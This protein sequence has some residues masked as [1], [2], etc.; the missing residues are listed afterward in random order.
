MLQ[1]LER[2]FAEGE[3][4]PKLTAKVDTVA[5]MVNGL[6]VDAK[7]AVVEFWKARGYDPK[8]PEI[9]REKLGYALDQE[10]ALGGV[11]V[12][13]MG[14]KPLFTGYQGVVGKRVNNMLT[15][16]NT[17]LKTLRRYG[18]RAEPDRLA[19]LQAPAK[20][21]LDPPPPRKR[22][23][24]EPASE[25]AARQGQASTSASA[26]VPASEP[27]PPPEALPSTTPTPMEL[28]LSMR[29]PCWFQHQ[30]W[31][32]P[33][34]NVRGSLPA[35]L[36]IYAAVE[37]E[38]L[39]VLGTD[40]D[41]MDSDD[42]DYDQPTEKL[43]MDAYNRYDA[44]LKSLAVWQNRSVRGMC[45]MKLARGECEHD[46]PC[47]CGAGVRPAW[48]WMLWAPDSRFCPDC[49]RDLGEVRRI[50]CQGYD[51]ISQVGLSRAL[52]AIPAEM[53]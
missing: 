36:A 13:A 15:P 33:R 38:Q 31:P 30:P 20:L 50:W 23:A 12:R 37:C 6:L 16:L 51:W 40:D 43:K 53:R 46:Q 21:N 27:P 42:E 44:V 52:E 34:R 18:A 41:F 7:K 9:T 28:P 11:V 5:K 35:A 49:R 47:G 24:P 10:D 22:P 2:M 25:P 45:C 17:K 1:L 26:S 4:E 48:P 29:C 14:L 39:G 8:K 19:L 32:C 3:G